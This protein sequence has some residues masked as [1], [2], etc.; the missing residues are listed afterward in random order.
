MRLKNAG[1]VTAAVIFTP[2]L[3]ACGSLSGKQDTAA[4]EA[5]AALR[6]IEVAVQ[7]GVSYQQYGPLLIE[8]K[9]K[10]N[11]AN[12][13]LPEG[14]LKNRLNS[15]MDAYVDAGQVWALKVGGTNLL[16]EREP[17]ATLMRKYNLKTQTISSVSLTYIDPD[18]AMQAMW[19]AAL[20]HLL[21]AQKVLDEQ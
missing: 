12:T 15:A 5:V 2:L 3:I 9:S 13:V 6:K 4:R 11:E 14:E 17:G 20:G 1:L 7:V 10:V 8:A 19:G 16:P 18:E 21:I